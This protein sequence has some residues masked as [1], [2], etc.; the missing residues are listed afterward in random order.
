VLLHLSLFFIHGVSVPS[1]LLATLGSDLLPIR[2]P[3]PRRLHPS[4]R[5]RARVCL[6]QLLHPSLVARVLSRRPSRL[7]LLPRPLTHLPAR[8]LRRLGDSPRIEPVVLPRLRR[9]KLR[10]ETR[11]RRESLLSI[12]CLWATSTPKLKHSRYSTASIF[13][14]VNSSWFQDTFIMHCRFISGNLDSAS[15]P[16][17]AS[18]EAVKLFERRFE[19]LTVTELKRQGQIG[20][21]II[22]ASEVKVSLIY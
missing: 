15:A 10:P 8:L 13:L 7:V 19:G 22:K 5:P 14:R 17:S 2:L 16:T 12:R 1:N 18:P 21:L 20:Q 6:R 4:L 3:G 9:P 11:R